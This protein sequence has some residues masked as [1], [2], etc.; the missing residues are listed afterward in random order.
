M[1]CFTVLSNEIEGRIDPLFYDPKYL[2]L[3]HKLQKSK[4][5]IKRIGDICSRIVDGPFG[6]QLKVEDYTTEGIPVVRVSNVKTGEISENNLVKISPEKHAELKRSRVLP[7]DVLLT[8]AG[9]ILGYSAVFP[10]RLIE[11]NITSHLVTITC[12]PEV[13]PYYLKTY[14]LSDVGSQQIY[15]WGNKSTRPELNTEEV[16]KILIPIPSIEI[17]TQIVDI[18]QSAYN[19]KKQK[20]VKA[21]RLLDS[22]DGYVLDDLGIKLPEVE[23]EMCFVV[24]SAEVQNSRADVAYYQPKFEEVEKALEKGKY[25]IA[26]LKE[27]VTKIHYGVSIKNV[28]V[29]EG[30]PLL[31]ILNIEPNKID[32]TEIAHLE[33]SKRKEIGSGFV[34]EGDLLVSRSGS[35]GIV[36]VVP[37]EADGFAFGSF[38][39]KFCV[40]DEVNKE[41]VS[42]WLN[43]KISKLFTERE[44][45]GAIQGN[46]TIS[47]IENFLVPIPPLEI[48]NKI[49]D[50]VKR[51]ISEAERLKAEATRIIEEAK[52]RVEGMILGD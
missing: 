24:T 11:G 19:Q 26:K 34:Y 7:N 50:E 33:E 46:I 18:M 2:Q 3:I 52:H 28:Y 12:K 13:N 48:Q 23:D 6:T 43:N 10:D 38:M 30:I 8:K 15:R 44:K 1:Q 32:L 42:I 27:F 35:V 39:I 20:K 36:A 37:K 29:D 51:R 5:E 25:R 14:L 45:I 22:I 41:Y 40:N 9:A 16:K 49:S 47:T 4:Y 17:Q 31:R 21:Q